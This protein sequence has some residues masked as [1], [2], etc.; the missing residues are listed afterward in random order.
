M[1]LP[2]WIWP[3]RPHAETTT[4]IRAG[5]VVHWVA[6]V[7]TALLVLAELYSTIDDM[8]YGGLIDL[9]SVIVASLISALITFAGRGLR[10][11]F[12]NE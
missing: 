11:I 10:Y 7:C 3:N 5:R 12:A 4:A 9:S 2:N 1:A 8:E 6:V